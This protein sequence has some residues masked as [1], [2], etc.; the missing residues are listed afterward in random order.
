MSLA[1]VVVW[2]DKSIGTW[3][4]EGL[5]GVCKGNGGFLGRND[6]YGSSQ[7]MFGLAAVSCS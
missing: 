3:L 5:L 2:M 7:V 6:A 4:I 1:R